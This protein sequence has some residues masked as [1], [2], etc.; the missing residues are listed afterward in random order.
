MEVVGTNGGVT[1]GKNIS[2]HVL[3]NTF[4]AVNLTVPA[5][6]AV[7][8][9]R[10]FALEWD[11][12]PNAQE[13]NLQVSYHSNFDNLLIDENVNSTS[14]LITEHTYGVTSGATYYWRVK[15]VNQCAQG[16]F[17]NGRSFTTQ[18]VN[19]NQEYN[20]NAITIP[21]TANPNPFEST[22]NFTQAAN[23][24]RVKVYVDITHSRISDLEIKVK[25]PANTEVVLDQFGT[26]S[27]NYQNIQVSYDDLSENYLDCKSS[28]PAIRDD[29]KPFETL[30]AFNG[31]NAQGNWKLIV[32]DPT[33]GEGGS[34]NMW[35]L[36]IC[37]VVGINETQDFD[38][39]RVW[40]NPSKGQINLELSAGKNIN[41]QLID[42][43]GRIVFNRKYNNSQ[44]TFTG[45]VMFGN[46]KKG[47]YLLHV[48]SGDQ[49]GLKRIIIK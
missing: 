45:N 7:D 9:V 40:P 30:G 34:L 24:S 41:V 4:T 44:E 31:E 16:N 10:P 48:S 15:P 37:E 21:A 28:S 13:Y 2:L 20:V 1:Q 42:I 22:I 33:N 12:N 43:S 26:C 47:I 27:G 8:M 38:L 5:D 25:S 39:F 18:Q 6:G 29:I 17:S 14:Y 19:C 32:S 36:E 11:E 35:A 3:K 46:L 49:Q 23:I